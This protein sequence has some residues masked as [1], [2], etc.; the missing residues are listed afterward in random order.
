MSANKIVCLGGGSLYFRR[1]VPDLLLR[2][3]LA[4]SEIVLYDIDAEKAE[5]MAAM[6]QRLAARAGTRFTVRGTGDLEAAVDGADFALSSIGGSGAEVTSNVYESRFH[7]ADIRIPAKYG[8]HQIIGDTGG[9]AGMMMALRSIPAYL[10]I[11]R[12]MEKRC[13]EAILLN[14]SNPMAVLCRALHKYTELEVV[15]ICHGVQGGL[16]NVAAILDV[17]AEELACTW[18]GT[19]HYYWFTRV[20]HKGTDVYPLLM[21]RLSKRLDD[22]GHKLSN[23]LSQIYGYRIVYPEDDH[24]WE[25][26]P[27]AA[28]PRSF[29]DLPYDLKAAAE[30]HGVDLSG[31]MPDRVVAS[32]EV[33]AQFFGDYQA[34]LDRVKLPAIQDHQSKDSA[35]YGEAIGSA[36][37]AIAHGRR[38]L[39]ISNL[40]NGGL[41]PNLS[42][43]GIVEVEAVTDSRG[44]RGIQSQEAPVALRGILEKR[45]A[46][47]E[48]VADA[49]VKGDRG[50]ALQA[51]L[52]DEMAILPDKAGDMLDELLEA[53]GDLLP[54]FSG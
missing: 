29:S 31:S 1:A 17:P 3:D 25:F 46:W 7:N 51:L 15:G 50:L 45:F 39:T 8:I 52:L 16:A 24:I 2:E 26:Y 14:H 49:G 11:C 18:I 40:P 47:H 43:T 21:D 19:N 20:L 32:K 9:P 22:E 41:I 48:L 4:E 28:A 44:V 36:I 54:Q 53:S 23:R 6:G 33:R 34:I 13:P 37:G 12:E 10:R 27:F 30:R 5:R 35:I 38:Q 42:A